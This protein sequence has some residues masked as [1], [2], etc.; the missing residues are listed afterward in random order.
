MARKTNNSSQNVAVIVS[1]VLKVEHRSDEGRRKTLR[2]A[3]PRLKNIKNRKHKNVRKSIRSRTSSSEE[4]DDADSEANGEEDDDDADED[5]NGDDEE[6]A[7]LAPPARATRKTGR[8]AGRLNQD[9]GDDESDDT[10][11]LLHGRRIE[12]KKTVRLNMKKLSDGSEEREESVE[13]VPDDDEDDYAGVNL[14]S[15]SD[16]EEPNLERE[17]E[18]NIIEDLEAKGNA[19]APPAHM[20]TLSDTSGL[21]EPFDITDHFIPPDVSFFDEEYER[22]DGGLN[23][24]LDF[25][26]VDGILEDATSLPKRDTQ[27]RVRF[28]TPNR[29]T[30]DASDL[31]SDDGDINTLFAGNDEMDSAHLMFGF[32]DDDALND[33]GEDVDSS[34]GS[35]SGYESR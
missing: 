30:S 27:R 33:N 1:P 21:W 11:A 14:I 34:C 12:E 15:D 2:P 6:P 35:S 10:K 31:V 5:G 18:R 26:S 4:E 28:Q 17:E 24:E 25:L 9:D 13:N 8:Q 29:R 22:Y 3:Q 32:G 19:P 7:V 23:N 20:S 16:E